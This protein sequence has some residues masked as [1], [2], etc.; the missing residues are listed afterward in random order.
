MKRIWRLTILILFIL[1]TQL[2]VI[3]PVSACSPPLDNWPPTL[4]G[5][6][7]RADNVII[8]K[9]V[10]PPDPPSHTIK[11]YGMKFLVKVESYLKGQGP[12]TIILTGF[13]YGT[14][15]LTQVQYGKLIFFID[16][17]PNHLD[18]YPLL[19]E[20]SLPNKD[21]LDSDV[22]YMSYAYAHGGLYLAKPET[23]TEIT[24]IANQK[25]NKPY[26]LPLTLRIKY[27][28]YDPRFNTWLSYIAISFFVITFSSIFA[29][30]QY[31]RRNSTSPDPKAQ[32]YGPSI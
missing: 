4:E 16:K 20:I 29:I 10:Y 30:R 23:I 19:H 13:G 8:G 15:C 27:L 11:V 18:P 5:H 3:N 32:T 26:G 7:N 6:V 25:P 24:E 17:T 21:N 9:I 2:I 31:K 22:Y 1:I 14:D 12:D 28:R